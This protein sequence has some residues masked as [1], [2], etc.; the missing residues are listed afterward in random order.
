MVNLCALASWESLVGWC[1]LL[2][3]VRTGEVVIP[4]EEVCTGGLLPTDELVGTVAVVTFYGAV[5]KSLFKAQSAGYT[6]KKEN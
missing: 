1:A 4:D 6:D 3:L 5:S 2:M